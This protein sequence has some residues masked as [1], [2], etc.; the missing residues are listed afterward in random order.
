MVVTGKLE[1][2]R[3]SSKGAVIP[4]QLQLT[5]AKRKHGPNVPRVPAFPEYAGILE[6]KE[7]QWYVLILE[8]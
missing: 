8:L 2:A 5:A 7:E 6:Q 1:R 4:R 3:V